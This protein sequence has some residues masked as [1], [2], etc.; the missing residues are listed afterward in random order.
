MN[1]EYR[2]QT[3]RELNPDMNVVKRLKKTAIALARS[4]WTNGNECS[5]QNSTRRQLLRKEQTVKTKTLVEGPSAG[6]CEN[7]FYY[8]L[9]AARTRAK[10]LEI[11]Y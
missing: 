5:S 11:I 8:K 1:Q 9:N 10:C 3:N 4:F 6:I 2:R 7:P